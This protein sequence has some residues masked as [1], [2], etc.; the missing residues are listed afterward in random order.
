MISSIANTGYALWRPS[1]SLIRDPKSQAEG[2]NIIYEVRWL[3][4]RLMSEKGPSAWAHPLE[5][6]AIGF[7]VFD[8]GVYGARH[9]GRDGGV[10]LAAQMGVVSVP[11]DIAFELV[12]EAIG[13]FENGH[14][15]CHPEGSAQPGVAV[16]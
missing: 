8:H 2:P 1:P 9:L 15:A 5:E 11:R 14:L 3:P 7:A 4:P 12:T 13:T 10:G 16:F 6:G